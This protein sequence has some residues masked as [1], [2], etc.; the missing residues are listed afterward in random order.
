MLHKKCLATVFHD[1]IQK[2]LNEFTV[3]WNSHY[4]RRNRLAN[5]PNGRP[6]DLFD[7]PEHY[8]MYHA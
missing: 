2:E 6:D 7:M 3:L 8:G 4:M 5:C 1:L